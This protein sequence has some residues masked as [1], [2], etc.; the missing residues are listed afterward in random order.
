[1]SGCQSKVSSIY[2]G[3]FVQMFRKYWSTFWPFFFSFCLFVLFLNMPLWA[4]DFYTT[5]C[6]VGYC[7]GCCT[8][9]TY[10]A[11]WSGLLSGLVSAALFYFICSFSCMCRRMFFNHP[12]ISFDNIGRKHWQIIVK[13]LSDFNRFLQHDPHNVIK[14]SEPFAESILLHYK[15]QMMFD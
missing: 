13:S 9:V 14:H 10:T 4:H 7:Q 1:M 15:L 12:H 6:K 3:R 2:H 8:L 5:I 11:E